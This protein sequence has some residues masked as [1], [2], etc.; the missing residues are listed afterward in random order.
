MLVIDWIFE[1]FPQILLQK[2]LLPFN[3]VRV[4]E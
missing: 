3:L 4:M 1:N 2:Y